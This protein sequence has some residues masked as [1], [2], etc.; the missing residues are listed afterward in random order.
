[1]QILEKAAE[2]GQTRQIQCFSTRF[3]GADGAILRERGGVSRVKGRCRG[4]KN[5][6][7]S[8]CKGGA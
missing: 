2:T 5:V 6:V 8:S 3:G 7:Q 1:M 4:R